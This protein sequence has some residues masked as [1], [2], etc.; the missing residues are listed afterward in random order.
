M[1]DPGEKSLHDVSFF[2]E[3]YMMFLESYLLSLFIIFSVFYF[4]NIHG[5]SPDS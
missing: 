3:D 5:V 4:L 2:S 1:H